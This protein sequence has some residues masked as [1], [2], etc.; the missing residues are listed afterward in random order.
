V[1]APGVN[2]ALISSVPCATAPLTAESPSLFSATVTGLV[3]VGT[4][5][6]PYA[7]PVPSS[8]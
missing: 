2:V 4:A 6:V 3:V 7:V 1:V 5:V 8:V